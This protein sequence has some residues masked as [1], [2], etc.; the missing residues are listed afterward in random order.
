M[1]VQSHADATAAVL[2]ANRSA[3]G[4]AQVRGLD[5]GGQEKADIYYFFN[6]YFNKK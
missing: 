4:Q 1:R 5:T 3:L 6:F 2:K